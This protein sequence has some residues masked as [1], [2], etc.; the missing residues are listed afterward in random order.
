MF[1]EV[2][3]FNEKHINQSLTDNLYIFVILDFK[4]KMIYDL[5]SSWH[6]HILNTIRNKK[7]CEIYPYKYIDVTKRYF[8]NAKIIIDSFHVMENIIKPWL[9]QNKKGWFNVE[10]IPYYLLLKIF[11]G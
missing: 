2:L 7:S 4:T 11:S 1:L 8:R 9:N 10:F 5:L 6:K 3:C